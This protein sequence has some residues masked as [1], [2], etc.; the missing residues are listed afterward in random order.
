MVETAG[1]A[2]GGFVEE[3]GRRQ[4]GVEE[5]KPG[6]CFLLG[7]WESE[8]GWEGAAR[9]GGVGEGDASKSIMEEVAGGG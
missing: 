8:V 9:G 2:G 5:V 4:S 7:G 1:G 6:Q 3:D